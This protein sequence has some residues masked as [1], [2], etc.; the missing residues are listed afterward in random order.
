MK[1]AEQTIRTARKH[2]ANNSARLCL[3]DAIYNYDKGDYASAYR[4]ALK[5][6][7]HSVGVFHPDYQACA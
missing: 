6:I 7:A 1:K 3:S 4:R 5:S 2:L